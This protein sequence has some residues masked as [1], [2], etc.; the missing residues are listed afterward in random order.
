MIS[1]TFKELT[2]GLLINYEAADDAF[3]ALSDGEAIPSEDDVEGLWN[4]NKSETRLQGG[5]SESHFLEFQNLLLCDLISET[6][7]QVFLENVKTAK[8]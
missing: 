3:V 5:I 8:T 2:D 1:R 4:I 7:L 6:Q